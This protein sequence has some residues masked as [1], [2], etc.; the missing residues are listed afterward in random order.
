MVHLKQTKT[1]NAPLGDE[2]IPNSWEFFADFLGTSLM[3]ELCLNNIIFDRKF[4]KQIVGSC[5]GLHVLSKN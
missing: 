4:M 1:L 5:C 3:S 2:K